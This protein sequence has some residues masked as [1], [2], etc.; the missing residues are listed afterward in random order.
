MVKRL[1]IIRG[2]I[3]RQGL[4]D[5]LWSGLTVPIDTEKEQQKT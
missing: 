5:S 2:R 1:S 4:W 3:G